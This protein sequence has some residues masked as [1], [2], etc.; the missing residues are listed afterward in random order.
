[1]IICS[2]GFGHS[3]VCEMLTD[4]D[5][6]SMLAGAVPSL[7]PLLRDWLLEETW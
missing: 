4:L 5:R 7:R 6:V 3:G 1:M 2:D